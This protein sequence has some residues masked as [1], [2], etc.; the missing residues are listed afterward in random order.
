M[1]PAYYHIVLNLGRVSKQCNLCALS[2]VKSYQT[3]VKSSQL[4]YPLL[5]TVLEICFVSE[6]LWKDQS[7]RAWMSKQCSIS[8]VWKHFEIKGQPQCCTPNKTHPNSY[9]YL[10]VTRI[11]AIKTQEKR[12]EK[13]EKLS[14]VVEYYSIIYLP[15][16]LLTAN[17]G[18]TLCTISKGLKKER[19]K[20][21]RQWKTFS[22]NTRCHRINRKLLRR[23]TKMYF[24]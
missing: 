17:N 21:S 9:K 20:R 16:S 1:V 10:R 15:E 7:L 19:R 5:Q 14:S 23:A 11:C 12:E 22:S 6:N 8:F 2:R 13:L 18:S 4:I 24:F 3:M